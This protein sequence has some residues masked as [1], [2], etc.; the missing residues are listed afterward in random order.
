MDGAAPVS[1]THLLEVIALYR[2]CKKDGCSREEFL[3]RAA[4][5]PGVYVDVYKR[6]IQIRD[7]AAFAQ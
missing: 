4:Q 7:Q 5:I 1:Y 3:R 2:S 6:Q